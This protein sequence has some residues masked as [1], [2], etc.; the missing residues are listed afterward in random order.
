M[1]V[2]DAVIEDGDDDASTGESLLPGR[3][4]VHIVSSIGASMLGDK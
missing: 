4:N 1:I 3:N 2:F